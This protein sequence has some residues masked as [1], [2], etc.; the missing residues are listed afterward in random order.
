MV[1]AAGEFRAGGSGD[2]ELTRR[3]CATEFPAATTEE[4]RISAQEFFEQLAMERANV[5]EYCELQYLRMA[6]LTE[7]R[8]AK[9]EEKKMRLEA[10]KI[11]ALEKKGAKRKRKKAGAGSR[12]ERCWKSRRQRSY[13]DAKGRPSYVAKDFAGRCK[14]F[15]KR[16]ALLLPRQAAWVKDGSRLK[17]ME[18]ARQIGIS[19]TTAYRQ[20]S[21][22][23]LATARL[24]SWISSRDEIQA[25]L[26]LEDCKAFAKLLDAAAEDLGERVIDEAGHSAYVL[27]YANGLRTHSMSSNPDAQAGKRGDRV[28]DEFAL[29][30]DP[31]KLYAIAYPGI[32]WGGSLEIISTHRGSGNFFCELVNEIKHKGNPKKFS[33]HTI[34]LQD[35]LE[36]GFLYK[37]QA[38]L[39]PEDER[40]QL[41][42]AEYYDYIRAG[43]ADEESFQQEYCC[44]PADDQA[45]F[46]SYDLIAG[47][48]Y[49]GEERWERTLAE[50][51]AGGNPLYVGGDIGRERDLSVFWVLEKVGGVKFTRRIVVC[52]R[53]TFEAQ[54]ARL[55]ELLA[56]PNVMRAC[57]DNTG[58]GRQFVERAQ[59]RFGAYRVEAVTF[60]GAV[61]EELA[62][63]VRASFEDRS[64]RVPGGSV[65]A[66]RPAGHP[67]GD[68]GE[69][70]YPLY[71]GADGERALRPLLGAG[72]G[73]ACG[74][75][76]GAGV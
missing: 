4:V 76:D 21:S 7:E 71:G 51:E 43:C 68:D 20:V 44:L 70:E 67:E 59:E 11:A 63:P 18:K 9:L 19:W 17:L 13:Y 10:R 2:G 30:P 32:T 1:E 3:S 42:E 66:E 60:T 47:C 72:A 23:S 74:E 56:L 64:V 39:G 62:Y 29:H 33:L 31:R 53:E 37:L 27:Q 75:D 28:L 40:Q 65:G 61:K 15:P 69:R 73:A 58:I 36:E 57:I 25:R 14:V 38:K 49:G 46:L 24:D 41:D 48:E 16:N 35:A 45:A 52:D 5:K 6:K 54:E 12:R 55:D 26:F 8:K 22:K 50:L 34:S